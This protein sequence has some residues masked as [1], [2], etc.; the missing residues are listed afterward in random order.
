MSKDRIHT[1]YLGSKK[2]L[3]KQINAGSKKRNVNPL[4]FLLKK[5]RNY[6]LTLMA[7]NCPF[8]SWRIMFHRWRGVKIGTNVTI[9]YHVTLD[10]SYPEYIEIE[11]NASLSGDNYILT[12]T[13]PKTHWK[14]VVESYIDPVRIKNGAWLTIGVKVLPGVTIGEKS[15]VTAGSVVNKNIPGK[16]LAGGIPAI[17]LKELNLVDEYQYY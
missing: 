3:K 13:T 9:G 17:V 7:Y 10:H 15:I 5:I 8:N 16:V 4:V 12:H 6:F 2:S 11:D 1:P 14:G